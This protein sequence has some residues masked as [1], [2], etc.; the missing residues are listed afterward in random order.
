MLVLA[1]GCTLEGQRADEVESTTG[2]DDGWSAPTSEEP[3]P[4]DFLPSVDLGA[5]TFECST[6]TQDCP[7]G[8]K[9]MP[10]ANDGG[11]VWNATRCSPIAARPAGIG[12]TCTMLGGRSS[13]LDDCDFGSMCWDVDHETLTGHCIPTCVG[14][15]G[16]PLCESPDRHC[17]QS[18][19]GVPNPCLPK[20]DPLAQDCTEGRGCYLYSGKVFL[21]AADGSGDGGASYDGCE[22]INVCDPGLVCVDA[23][24]DAACPNSAPGC[25][26]TICE[27][28][29]SAPTCPPLEECVPWEWTDD[30]IPPEL[31]N[32]GLC[33]FPDL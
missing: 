3:M 7:A 17:V 4:S 25:C 14:D 33:K 27:V 22:F 31:E 10:Y 11:A 30:E 26:K 21:C 5:A 6:W 9:C 1:V 16:N 2:S 8:Q 29:G 28:S 32:L 13:G 23:T 12:D 15:P 18:G 20:C 19:S 24:D